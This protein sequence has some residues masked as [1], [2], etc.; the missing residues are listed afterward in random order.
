M[1][2][3]DT[4][5]FHSIDLNPGAT[6][7]LFTKYIEDL[8]LFFQ[9]IF[10]KSDGTPYVPSEKEK[11]ALLLLKGGEDMRN[12]LEYV[13]KIAETDTFAQIVEKVKTGLSER[14][15][16][17]VQRNLLF[18]NFPQGKKSFEKWSQ[19][20][21][22]AA[23]LISYQNYDWKKATVDAILLQTSNSR[24]RERALQE[25][26]SYDDLMKMGVAKEQSARGAA[27]LEK[28]SG[29]SSQVRIKVE[30]EVR[31]LQLE[32]RDLKSRLSENAKCTR[33][34][35]ENCSKSRCP[36]NGRKCSVCGKA[37][38]L[39]QACR[40][41]SEKNSSKSW[42]NPKKG[43]KNRNPVRQLSSAED[44]ESESESSGRIVVGHLK[45][46]SI[47]AKVGIK[48]K[49]P[50][51]TSKE[52]M[53]ATDT[54]ISKTLLNRADWE[55]IRDGCK[56]VKTSKRFRPYGTA[57]HLPI[58]GKAL[59]T[60]TAERGAEIETWVYVVDDQKESSLLGET[61]AIRLGI[62]KLDLKG[63]KEEIVNKIEYLNKSDVKIEENDYNKEVDSEMDKIRS[64]FADVISDTTGKVK[65]PPIKIQFQEDA[66]PTIQ[67]PRRI[68]LHYMSRRTQK[69]EIRRYH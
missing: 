4:P 29:S 25:N 68:P 45:T 66:T 60:L 15:N 43:K 49:Y 30:E 26:C 48:G 12:L 34:G 10:R 35:S 67:P 69:N 62:V 5:K 46:K 52:I 55:S 39:A 19:E 28:A 1:A 20:I 57:Y 59:V 17:V 13:G 14:T 24:L 32:N 11:G 22:N 61:D 56:F 47:Q 53:L 63:S 31:K 21:S 44:S 7:Q 3:L 38:H 41:K 16:E 58:K 40:S 8:E 6:L 51:S 37:N 36:A 65:G 2:T 54:G 42:K 18:A 9:L 64:E 27:L 23:K 33:C 50:G